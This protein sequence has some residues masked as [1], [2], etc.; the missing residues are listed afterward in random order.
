MYIIVHIHFQSYEI[1]Q[2]SGI[3]INSEENRHSDVKKILFKSDIILF[4][5]LLLLCLLD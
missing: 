4:L 3:L 2:D 5:L 1:K